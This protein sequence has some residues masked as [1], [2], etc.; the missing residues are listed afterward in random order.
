MDG[1]FYGELDP[2]RIFA[3]GKVLER[4]NTTLV[5]AATN[6]ELSKIELFRISQRMHDGMARAVNPVH[7]SYDG[8]MTF[9]LSW[10]NVRTDCDHVAEIAAS[11]TSEAIRRAVLAAKS[12][13]GIPGLSP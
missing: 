8:D 1:R 9:A 11:L 3:R 6:A 2:H 13:Q 7:S 4:T 12:V 5:V 10:G